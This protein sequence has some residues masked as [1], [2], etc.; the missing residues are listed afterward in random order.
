MLLV[1][2]LPF[3]EVLDGYGLC[4]LGMTRPRAEGTHLDRN[5]TWGS[6]VEILTYIHVKLIR[7]NSL[8]ARFKSTNGNI[9]TKISGVV[10]GVGGLFYPLCMQVG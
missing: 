4:E 5:R 3:K 8:I 7:E 1:Y 10:R 2:R 6:D 9:Y